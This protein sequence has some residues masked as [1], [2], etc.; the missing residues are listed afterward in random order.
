MIEIIVL[1]IPIVTLVK[2][3][4][5]GHDFT[6]RQRPFPMA[7]FQTRAQQLTVPQR[8]KALAKIIDVAEQFF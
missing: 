7:S 2:G 6:E 1:E 3:D 5:N 4:E 8:L